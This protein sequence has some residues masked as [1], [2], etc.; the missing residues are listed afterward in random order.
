M[1]KAIAHS[2]SVREAFSVP[3]LYRYLIPATSDGTGGAT[4]VELVRREEERLGIRGEITLIGRR[5]VATPR[6]GDGN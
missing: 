5:I 6:P 3:Y 4:F 2:F 1:A